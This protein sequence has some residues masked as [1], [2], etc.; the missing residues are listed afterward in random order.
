MLRVCY[1]A[2]CKHPTI[3]W[4]SGWLATD[5]RV[6]GRKRGLQTVSISSSVLSL[7]LLQRVGLRLSRQVL[8]RRLSPTC[9]GCPETWKDDASRCLDYRWTQRTAAEY[10]LPGAS[11]SQV[12]GLSAVRDFRVLFQQQDA[13]VG[14]QLVLSHCNVLCATDYHQYSVLGHSLRDLQQIQSPA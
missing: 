1:P 6:E 8:C 4:F 9:H 10:I 11:S 12:S 13:G 2:E 3:F 5:C 7:S 14:L